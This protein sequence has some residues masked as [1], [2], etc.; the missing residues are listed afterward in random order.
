MKLRGLALFLIFLL[1]GNLV[2]TDCNV[3]ISSTEA[4][5]ACLN[6]CNHDLQVDKIFN[7]L[8]SEQIFE[9][10][11]FSFTTEALPLAKEVSYYYIPSSLLDRPPALRF[12]AEG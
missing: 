3:C 6:I 11:S 9:I 5:L 10:S 4:V 7:D 8:I 12:P 1:F 2:L